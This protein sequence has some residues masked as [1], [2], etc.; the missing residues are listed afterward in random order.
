MQKDL[1]KVHLQRDLPETTCVAL[2]M[3]LGFHLARKEGYIQ[4]PVMNFAALPHCCTLVI[5]I[6]EPESETGLES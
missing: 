5:I 1:Q 3:Y 2:L 4:A 6:Q